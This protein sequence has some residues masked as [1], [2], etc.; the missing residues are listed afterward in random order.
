MVE[1]ASAAATAVA[2]LASTADGEVAKAASTTDEASLADK[3]VAAHRL[4]TGGGS[5]GVRTC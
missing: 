1:A 2:M 3:A 5:A 4:K